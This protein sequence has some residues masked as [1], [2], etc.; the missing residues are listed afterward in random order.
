M[1]LLRWLWVPP[2]IAA[3]LGRWRMIYLYDGF[4][5]YCKRWPGSA[6]RLIGAIARS[7]LKTDALMEML[8]SPT[9]DPW[10]QR[11][12][13]CPDGDFFN[14]L[15]CGEASIVKGSASGFG[16]PRSLSLAGGG[17]VGDLDVVVTATGMNLQENFPMSRIAVT[18]DGAS[19]VAKNH[20]AYKSLMLSG[21]P[22]LAFSM[23]YTNIPWTLR[24]DLIGSYVAKLVNHMHATGAKKVVPTPGST[25]PFRVRVGASPPL[26]S[27]YFLRA[28]E[29]MPKEG[30]AHPWIATQDFFADKRNLNRGPIDDEVIFSK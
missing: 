16:G 22:N 2:A 29:C 28:I 6:R 20:F 8:G 26:S 18:V 25:K 13:A 15:A 3:T 24:S 19:Y 7:Y 11:V 21:V 12:C 27:S 1:R 14:S 30:H 23:G 9:Y 17:E 4:Y 5:K 10:D